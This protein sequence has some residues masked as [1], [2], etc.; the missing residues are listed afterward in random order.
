MQTKD[1][2]SYQARD[3]EPFNGLRLLDC[4]SCSEECDSLSMF[5]LMIFNINKPSKY[6]DR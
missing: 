2:F 3:Q 5:F 1:I 6:F 4:D